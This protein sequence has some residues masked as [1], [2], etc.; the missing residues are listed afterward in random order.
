MKCRLAS[1]IKLPLDNMSYLISLQKFASQVSAIKT[2]ETQSN[3][4]I[5]AEKYAAYT[6]PSAQLQ[7]KALRRRLVAAQPQ[8]GARGGLP[9]LQEMAE[10]YTALGQIKN[11]KIQ[12]AARKAYAAQF[13]QAHT[14]IPKN[15][16]KDQAATLAQSRL[17]P[18]PTAAPAPTAPT[19]PT[20][21]K[22]GF[23]K[24]LMAGGA[25]AGLGALGYATTQRP[26]PY[27]TTGGISY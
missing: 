27:N 24:G 15:M 16:P 19:A 17:R 25:V 21:S 20:P 10:Q 9:S 7:A 13:G 14:P 11:P 18:A 5:F 26:P 6:L 3:F 4:V 12:L 22:W 8:L 23:G 2:A 1:A